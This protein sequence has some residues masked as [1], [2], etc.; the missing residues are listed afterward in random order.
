M[1]QRDTVRYVIRNIA[2]NLIAIRN[3]RPLILCTSE[4]VQRSDVNCK[5][6]SGFH[7]QA[8]PVVECYDLKGL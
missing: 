7:S 1:S 2:F 3:A 5:Q 8:G 6:L 4:L